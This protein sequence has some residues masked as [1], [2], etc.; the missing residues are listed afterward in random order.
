MDY[1]PNSETLEKAWPQLSASDR[2]WAADTLRDYVDQLRA[3]PPPPG[4]SRA[5]GPFGENASIPRPCPPM[6]IFRNPGKGRDKADRP[7]QS[8]ADMTKWFDTR[9][10]RLLLYFYRMEGK[11]PPSDSGMLDMFDN[12]EPLVMSHGDLNMCN[13]LLQKS[14][15]GSNTSRNCG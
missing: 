11:I 1:I 6:W 8:Y 2:L 4:W 9:R 5:P 14:D 15:D 12:R 3:V 7:F 10:A 13:I